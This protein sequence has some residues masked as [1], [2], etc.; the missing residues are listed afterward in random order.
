M[1][2]IKVLETMNL[3]NQPTS[4]LN[5]H[6]CLKEEKTLLNS[7]VD[8]CKKGKTTS[9]ICWPLIKL[10]DQH[11]LQRKLEET[12][13]KLNVLQNMPFS[14]YISNSDLPFFST[15]F[16]FSFLAPGEMV[17]KE[18]GL[19][20]IV[21]EGEVDVH[22]VVAGLD[23]ATGDQRAVLCSKQ[24][25]DIIYIPAMNKYVNKKEMHRRATYR[26]GMKKI[27]PSESRVDEMKRNTKRSFLFTSAKSFP[28]N[29]EE[30]DHHRKDL[31]NL[32]DTTT[33][34]SRGGATLLCLNKKE[35]DEFIKKK[36]I[37]DSL[38]LGI[39]INQNESQKTD[40]N[41]KFKSNKVEAEVTA[42]N[43]TGNNFQNFINRNGP[44][45]LE[46]EQLPNLD[47]S[48]KCLLNANLDNVVLN[49]DFDIKGLKKFLETHIV[50]YLRTI[51]FLKI[52]P[53]QKLCLLAEMCHYKYVKKG[54][55]ICHEKEESNEVYIILDG[56]VDVLKTIISDPKPPTETL[57]ESSSE[58]PQ[59]KNRTI[60][61][62]SSD[63]DD[64]H[65]NQNLKIAQIHHYIKLKSLH[66][67]EYFG[68]M[69]ALLRVARTASIVAQEQCILIYIRRTDFRNFLALQP[70][71]KSGIQRELKKH[72][73]INISK[74]K[75]LQYQKGSE[76]DFKTFSRTTERQNFEYIEEV[77]SLM[78][79]NS[80]PFYG[81][82]EKEL[83][84]LADAV[85]LEELHG[86]GNI[87][88]QQGEKVSGLYFLISGEVNLALQDDLDINSE[89]DMNYNKDIS[90]KKEDSESNDLEQV[91]EDRDKEIITHHL[92]QN[93]FFGYAAMFTP[94]KIEPFT[95]YNITES[96]IYL[97]FP[98]ASFPFI[99]DRL[100]LLEPM[101]AFRYHGRHLPL[102]DALKLPFIK[103][104]FSM[105]L[106]KEFS[107]ENLA[108]IE[109]VEKLIGMFT[110]YL[111]HLLSLKSKL[112]Y[113]SPLNSSN[114]T[115]D[116]RLNESNIISIF[117]DVV[118]SGLTETELKEKI[119]LLRSFGVSKNDIENADD[120]IQNDL[121]YDMEA[122]RVAHLSN[123]SLELE[124]VIL[125]IDYYNEKFSYLMKSNIS[126]DIK[127][128][129]KLGKELI[130]LT[131]SVYE[132][133][134]SSKAIFPINIP[135][136]Q[137]AN[138]EEKILK[139]VK[140]M[141]EEAPIVLAFSGNFDCIKGLNW[142]HQ[143]LISLLYEFK[144]EERS[145]TTNISNLFDIPSNNNLINKRHLFSHAVDEIMNLLERDNFT[146]FKAGDIFN[147]YLYGFTNDCEYCIC[148][149]ENH[150]VI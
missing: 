140:I 118:Q 27:L 83:T 110:K 68:E 90:L 8:I 72:L 111:N 78:K 30:S 117:D 82:D 145:E 34:I 2:C 62:S 124:R 148:E 119:L 36:E 42:M 3:R 50:E 95:A 63:D 4:G 132:R 93:K 87:I 85:I 114:N 84:A 17:S 60:N 55:F 138:I 139:L 121:N 53:P 6:A 38:N 61:S 77:R 22:T 21:A 12:K 59:N 146:R 99:F 98:V 81:L 70:R 142:I 136:S 109:H 79:E 125:L 107:R 71:L 86:E 43:I 37:P 150:V 80:N 100:P 122:A 26:E 9:L 104:S 130:R 116:T 105:H 149:T 134:I 31:Y 49:S 56:S 41:F 47:N 44:S 126:D 24:P 33:L 5:N 137:T 135:H 113:N 106:S 58:N 28:I 74:Q 103:T 52:V 69:S 32:I 115:K 39:E 108:F 131:M 89:V 64:S 15:F 141:F 127:T 29:K 51:P 123:I 10:N 147:Q 46:F 102:K 1:N 73:L 16:T 101:L 91:N 94:E 20:M 40:N 57:K 96:C 97:K 18:V 67:G 48:L 75:S 133:Y 54:E 35:F 143:N 88:L 13:L 14:K 129:V 144:Q 65:I 45:S 7:I 19:Y 66:S 92:G 76:K 112:I 120:I 25:G 11:I 128:F 23:K